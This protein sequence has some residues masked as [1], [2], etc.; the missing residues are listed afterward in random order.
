MRFLNSSCKLTVLAVLLAGCFI[1]CSTVGGDKVQTS[2]NAP[3]GVSGTAVILQADGGAPP[4]PPKT[5]SG[6]ASLA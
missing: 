6:S 5:N 2:K 4:P 1:A 3:L